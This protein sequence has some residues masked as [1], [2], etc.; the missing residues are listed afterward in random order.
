MKPREWRLRRVCLFVLCVTPMAAGAALVMASRRGPTPSLDGLQPLLAARRFDE[1]ER[2][3][4]DFLRLDQGNPQ[5]NL[6]LAQVCLARDD[7]K[8]QLALEH[9]ARI[10][11]GNRGVKAMIL[12]NQGKAY[13]SL[14]QNDRA[15][16]AW[17]EALQ[18]EP[19][20]PEAGWNLL[21]LYY[22]QGRR[23][24]ARRMGLALYAI[25]PDRAIV[26]N[27]S[28]SCFARTPSRSDRIR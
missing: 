5:A 16:S 23:D 26:R 12:L 7:Q 11:V 13:S 19:L 4:S 17:T 24:E 8:P 14:G 6:L 3:V 18:L 1:V 27:C 2:R 21:G 20:T 28:W 25:E 15:E 22:V 10:Q 9:L